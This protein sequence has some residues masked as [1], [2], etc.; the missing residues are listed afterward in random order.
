MQ[1]SKEAEKVWFQ[2]KKKSLYLSKFTK[3]YT[4]FQGLGLRLNIGQTEHQ[5]EHPNTIYYSLIVPFCLSANR[6]TTKFILFMYSKWIT[7]NV[8]LLRT[9]KEMALAAGLLFPSPVAGWE[10][11]R[12]IYE[13]IIYGFQE[14]KVPAKAQWMVTR[15]NFIHLP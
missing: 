5:D 10:G 4:S 13:R 2:V 14:V 7:A 6:S 3:S 15:P 9:A 8:K 12:I 1:L 11:I